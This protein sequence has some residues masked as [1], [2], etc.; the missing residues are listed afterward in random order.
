MPPPRDTCAPIGT[1]TPCTSIRR[2]GSGTNASIE[3]LDFHLPR[4]LDRSFVLSL[5]EGGW[6]SAHRHVLVT[7]PTGVGKTFDVCTLAQAALRRDITGPFGLQ[8]L[9]QAPAADLLELIEDRLG[10]RGITAGAPRRPGGSNRS[11]ATNSHC[12]SVRAIA[13]RISAIVAGRGVSF[14]GTDPPSNVRTQLHV[15]SSRRD[16]GRPGAP[17]RGAPRPRPAARGRRVG[18]GDG[19]SGGAPPPGA[20]GPGTPRSADSGAPRRRATRAATRCRSVVRTTSRPVSAWS[21]RS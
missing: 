7:G 1:V 3:D 21:P 18:S 12:S 10:R 17:S 15:L 2:T 4:G 14:R 6:V 19:A 8:P 9:T 5:A 13:K 20:R 11:S 16:V